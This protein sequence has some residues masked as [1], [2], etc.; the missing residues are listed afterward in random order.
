MKLVLQFFI[1]LEKDFW[2][3]LSDLEED[4]LTTRPLLNQPGVGGERLISSWWS[5]WWFGN[6]QWSW[7]WWYGNKECWSW[8]WWWRP[9][10][11]WLGV[12]TAPLSGLIRRYMR[13]YHHKKTFR[14]R[15]SSSSPLHVFMWNPFHS[16]PRRNIFCPNLKQTATDRFED[17]EWRLHSEN[18]FVWIS[19]TWWERMS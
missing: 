8:T 2:K 11:Q 19:R 5:L 9:S 16:K 13:K 1:Y 7:S 17:W 4:G 3:N 15:T 10:N 14:M 18:R 6:D 12:A